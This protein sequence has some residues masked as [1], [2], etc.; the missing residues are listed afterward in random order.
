VGQAATLRG[1]AGSVH[2]QVRSA[3]FGQASLALTMV[4]ITGS[5]NVVAVPNRSWSWCF[6]AK[7]GACAKYA[8]LAVY[9]HTADECLGSNGFLSC[10]ALTNTAVCRC[11]GPGERKWQRVDGNVVKWREERT[12]RQS[13]IRR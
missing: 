3:L 12:E 4:S 2:C 10:C 7:V 6:I 1:G 9:F 13:D 11:V 5:S 8:L